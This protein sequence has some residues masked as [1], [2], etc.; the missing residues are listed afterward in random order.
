MS[1]DSSGTLQEWDILQKKELWNVEFSNI[2]HTSLAMP[3][4]MKYFYSEQ[5]DLFG[6]L[7]FAST[8]KK[9]RLIQ[10]GC[11]VRKKYTFVFG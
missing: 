10:D 9:I 4:C 5:T 3:I 2:S 6:K 8:D 1:S 7:Y 11:L